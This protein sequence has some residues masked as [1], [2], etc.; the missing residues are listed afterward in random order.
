MP[1]EFVQYVTQ[2][3]QLINLEFIFRTKWNV[4]STLCA[5]LSNHRLIASR[6][7]NLLF[8][9]LMCWCVIFFLRNV[10]ME[11]TN[12]DRFMYFRKGSTPVCRFLATCFPSGRLVVCQLTKRSHVGTNYFTQTM[13]SPW[14]HHVAE[15]IVCSSSGQNCWRTLKSD[16]LKHCAV[17]RKKQSS[18][19]R[20]P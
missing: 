8:I 15:P 14:A 1:A 7:I 4:C 3:E 6:E 20:C 12:C 16:E 11:R 9:M 2:T 19:S 18:V 17:A 10:P 5:L 13:I